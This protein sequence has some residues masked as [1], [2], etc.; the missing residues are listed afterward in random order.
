MKKYTPLI[1]F[2]F[3]AIISFWLAFLGQPLIHGNEKAIDL[4]VNAFSI[5]T[6][7]LIA[8]MTL[9][10]EMKFDENANWR[11]L[12]LSQDLHEQRYTKHTFLFYNYIC[13][14]ILVFLVVLFKNNPNYK[15]SL[16]ICVLE[17]M[18]L[19]LAI[20][21][22]LYSIFLPNKLIQLRKEEFKKLLEKKSPKV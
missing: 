12:K 19:W 14:L 8:I 1:R 7:F 18:Y 9:F 16:L 13:V 17:V 10:S 3:F 4:I 21:S 20:L 5:L 15:D 22:L 11:R 2:V 6:G